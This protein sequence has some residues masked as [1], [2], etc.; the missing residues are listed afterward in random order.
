MKIALFLQEKNNENHNK[1]SLAIPYD[2][3][4]N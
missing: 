1:K 3:F 2:A 4:I